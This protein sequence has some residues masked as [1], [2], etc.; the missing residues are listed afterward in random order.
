MSNE[1]NSLMQAVD[2]LR[3]ARLEDEPGGGTACWRLLVHAEEYLDAQMVELISDPMRRRRIPT[4]N[5]MYLDDYGPSP[6]RKLAGW[7]GTWLN[8]L[9]EVDS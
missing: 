2:I 6:L 3:K 4:Q 8:R 9:S 5:P 1:M 7:L